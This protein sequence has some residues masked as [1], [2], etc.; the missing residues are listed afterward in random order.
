[1]LCSQETSNGSQSHG[2]EA[3]RVYMCVWVWDM[4]VWD[5][6]CVEVSVCVCVC[7]WVYTS[8][9]WMSVY[10]NESAQVGDQVGFSQV[11]RVAY[12]L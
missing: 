6:G 3:V 9:Q 8:D 11:K 12:S 7:K 2:G 10:T 5:G 4:W 1:M